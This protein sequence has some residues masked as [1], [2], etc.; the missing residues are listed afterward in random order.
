MYQRYRWRIWRFQSC[1]PPPLIRD[2][3][4]N[5]VIKRFLFMQH[6]NFSKHPLFYLFPMILLVPQHTL[7]GYFTFPNNCNTSS[8]D[9]IHL[10]GY[11]YLNSQ[12]RY[13]EDLAEKAKINFIIA[14]YTISILGISIAKNQQWHLTVVKGND[15]S[16]PQQDSYFFEIETK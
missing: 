3:V 7:D 6:D 8:V 9:F 10:F 12:P 5:N 13:F 2:Y 4:Q 11:L 16:P 14:V 15:H 1:L